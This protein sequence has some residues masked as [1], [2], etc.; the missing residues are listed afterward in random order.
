[1]HPQFA[2]RA[3]CKTLWGVTEEMGNCPSGYAKLF[4]RIAADGFNAVETPVWMIAD[5]AAFTA[6]LASAGLGYV[7]MVN[8]CTPDP[9]G[10]PGA[11]LARPSQKLADHV[12]SF[13]AQ[14]KEACAM[15]PLLINSHS[16]F[17]GWPLA[18]AAA[19]FTRALEVERACGFTV[20]HETHRGRVLYQPW[21]TRDL[22]RAFPA[23]KLTADLSH[24]CVVAERVF[25]EADEDWAAVMAEVA[26]A[27]VHIHARVGYAEGPQVPDPRA[28]EYEPA[29]TRHEA[30]WDQIL[31]AQAAAG[32]AVVTLEPEHGTDGYQQRL[33]YTGVETASIWDINS[34]IRRRQEAR[35]RAAAWA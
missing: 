16:G 15:A 33:P 1:M 7:A 29:L 24:F 35:L 25:H 34:W 19:F 28:P 32:R 14:V 8:T 20:A 22:C 21:I 9:A 12:A 10:P 13:E 18:D 3:S 5:K 6:A 27:T 11:T 2:P 23:L 4:A 17:D 30:W 26:R 31:A